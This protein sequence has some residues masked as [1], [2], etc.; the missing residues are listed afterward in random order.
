M[1]FGELKLD[2]VS[3]IAVWLGFCPMSALRK[4][5]AAKWSWR[6]DSSWIDYDA[7]TNLLIENEYLE[8]VQRVTV[9]GERFIDLSLTVRT[10]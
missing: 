2:F 3:P 1:V 7:K 8:N 4:L 5:T 9:D 6:G 10:Y